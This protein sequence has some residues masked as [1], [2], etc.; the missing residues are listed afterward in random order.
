MSAEVAS[1]EP[2]SAESVG[3]RRAALRIAF[4]TTLSFAIAEGLDW[5]FTFIGPMLAVQ[6]LVS[7]RRSPTLAAGLGFAAVIAAANAF[8]LLLSAAL[9]ETPPLLVLALALVLWVSFYAQLRGAPDFAT[10]MFQ[11]STVAIPVFA[12]ITP[13]LG[14]TMAE[15]LATGGLVA[16]L[17]AW[18]AHAAFPEPDDMRSPGAAPDLRA[19]LPTRTAAWTALRNTLIVMPVLIWYL[20]DD[21]QVA[22]VMLVVI[23]TVIRQYDPLQGQ[24]AA[25]GLVIGNLIGGFAAG[26]AYALIR[27]EDTIA[28]FA[29]VCLGASLLFAG[30][31]VTGGPRAPI[32]LIAF[33]TFI[34]VLGL[35]IT[36]LPGGSGEAF[37]SRLFYVV[38]ASIYAIGALSL[39]PIRQNRDV[40]PPNAA[41]DHRDS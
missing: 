1:T 13:E 32:Y 21:T 41:F 5:D 31:I 3:A 9:V 20:S 27:I 7:S 35:G 15:A 23:V 11:I 39:V 37:L 16:V 4:S 29:I 17:T 40:K 26:I 30:R 8:V 14:G 38:L 6:L 25:T 33:S 12:V 18:A 34:I 19:L 36:P 28:F 2:R 24:R 22:V 10:F